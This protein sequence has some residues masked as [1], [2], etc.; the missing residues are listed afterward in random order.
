MFGIPEGYVKE[1]ARMPGEHTWAVFYMLS[2]NHHEVE[3]KLSKWLGRIAIDSDEKAILDYVLFLYME[4]R[5]I[6]AFRDRENLHNDWI[7]KELP[8]ITDPFEAA[9]YAAKR[10]FP[11]SPS[12]AVINESAKLMEKLYKG[13]ILPFG[14]VDI[15]LPPGYELVNPNR[16]PFFQVGMRP[17]YWGNVDNQYLDLYVP[18][19]F[20]G[21]I[22]LETGYTFSTVSS[23]Y[24]LYT[25]KQVYDLL[26]EIAGGV[27][28]GKQEPVSILDDFEL[29]RN[30][31]VCKMS[32]RRAEEIYQPLLN[33]GWQA[34]LEGINSYDKSEP[35]KYT[36]GFKNVRYRASLLMPEY[37]VSIQTQHTIPFEEFRKKVLDTVARNIEFKAIENSFRQT[38]ESLRSTRLADRDMLP[39]F[40]K[41]FNIFEVPKTDG[42]KDRLFKTLRFIDRLVAE[43]IANYGKNAYALLHVI[44]GYMSDRGPYDAG[45]DW[46]LGKWVHDFLKATS[47]PGF[48]M[49]KYIEGVFYD[50]ASWYG[51]Q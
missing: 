41:Y 15:P 5:A 21:V 4:H 22:D 16:D 8:I 30:S 2:G 25:N 11:F 9:D 33:D 46:E 45:S 47:Q 24:C 19:R 49:S 14:A 18:S 26:V 40:C 17:L 51:M 35:L 39:L 13:Q 32:V 36:F 7:D 27:F 29:S 44:M 3:R 28:E 1:I 31:G 10:R 38:I 23:K 50:L 42:G 48:S 12:P 20:Y 37:T 34:V 43:N 6:I